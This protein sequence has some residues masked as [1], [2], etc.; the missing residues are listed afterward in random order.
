VHSEVAV[1][2]GVG[3]PQLVDVVALAFA[4]P[5]A[6]VEG[7]E[8][9]IGVAEQGVAHDEDIVQLAVAACDETAAQGLLSFVAGLYG[10]HGGGA[11]L[12]PHEF[13]VEEEVVAEELAGLEGRVLDAALCRG[14][15][16]QKGH[17]AEG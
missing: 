16:R 15:Q 6:E 2:V 13:P 3:V 17:Q 14:G 11:Y 4:C 1:V 7:C 5:F 10:G 8:V 12:D 9:G